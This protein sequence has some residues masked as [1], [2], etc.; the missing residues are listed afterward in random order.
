MSD[1]ILVRNRQARHLF[2]QLQ[3]LSAPVRA[4][5]SPE[6]LL[7]LIRQLGFV[8]V[9]SIQTVARA[10]HM[11][12]FARNQTYRPEA[13][14]GLLEQ[15]RDLFEH[16]T[17][18][19]A[20]IPAAFYPYWRH[21]FE[22]ERTRL[23]E[24]WQK[25]RRDGFVEVID[26]VYETVCDRGPTMAR[27]LGQDQKKPSG[28]WW[29][30]HPEK[31]A[32][33]YHWRT[34]NFAIS[35]RENFQKVYDLTERV[36]TPD[37]LS[38]E[39]DEAGFI[40]WA[41]QSALAR[42]GIATSGEMAAFWDL[43]KPAEAANWCKA[44]LEGGR[45]VEVTV[46][47]ADRKAAPRKAFAFPDIEQQLAEAA[48]PLKRL[49]L[50][51][52]FDPVIRDRKRLERLFGFDYRI[53]VFVPAAKRKYGY[54]VFP[55]LEGDRFIG[56]IDV[57]HQKDRDSLHVTGLWLEPGVGFGRQRERGLMAEL[58]RQRRFVGASA[59]TFEKGYHKC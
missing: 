15:S 5:Q 1:P 12:L 14:T 18:D 31:T 26:Q 45:L 59:V 56:R 36:L 50:L 48:P 43:I 10:H 30:W 35:G 7:D 41:C 33:E 42:L 23:K 6:D 17:H 44:E 47:G 16:W 46:E 2:M 29:N 55:I 57:K 4:K 20:V 38:A 58:D 8:Q 34:G 27:E 21:K 28:G 37:T 40:D 54:Y 22:R 11:I 13:L 25:W 24:R 39:C 3:G 53:E 19:A 32:L 49:R 52:P 51:S 9:D